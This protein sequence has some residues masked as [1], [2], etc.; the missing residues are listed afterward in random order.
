MVLEGYDIYTLS[1][2]RGLG[3]LKEE[4]P[5]WINY[6]NK[7]CVVLIITDRN[8]WE[9]E[10]MD[11][12]RSK[13]PRVK[14]PICRF[15]SKSSVS[16]DKRETFVTELSGQIFDRK[17]N[18]ISE[19]IAVKQD[20]PKDIKSE[21]EEELAVMPTINLVVNRC[22][23]HNAL[24]S[25]WDCILNRKGLDGYGSSVLWYE[26]IGDENYSLELG[27]QKTSQG[28]YVRKVFE[29]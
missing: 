1:T 10:A 2:Y 4:C 5:I 17:G 16:E 28:I 23:D 15:L 29:L 26:P 24:K 20:I 13:F 25:L 3:F 6:R 8:R 12:I 22:S 7:E 18:V 14:D 21:L 19:I 27:F 9:E 11:Y